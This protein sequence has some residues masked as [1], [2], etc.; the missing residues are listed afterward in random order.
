MAFSGHQPGNEQLFPW[1][2]GRGDCV[3]RR[4]SEVSASRARA[5]NPG[6]LLPH[7]L[8]VIERGRRQRSPLSP[9]AALT[10]TFHSPWLCPKARPL[11]HT[12][13]LLQSSSVPTAEQRPD[14]MLDCEQACPLPADIVSCC[15]A[16]ASLF[17]LPQSAPAVCPGNSARACAPRP[18]EG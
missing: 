14:L 11:S 6:S 5:A 1:G 18:Q 15:P 10:A 4:S 16:S 9:H 17:M 8:S 7:I 3:S 12:W 2:L 13:G